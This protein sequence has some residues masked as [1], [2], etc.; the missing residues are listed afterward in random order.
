MHSCRIV[1]LCRYLTAFV[2]SVLLLLS[3]RVLSVE[4]APDEI[5][6][7]AEFLEGK[8]LQQSGQWGSSIEHFRAAADAYSFVAD[9]ALYQMAQS[10]RQGKNTAVAVS[11]L[12][13]LLALYPN[14]P[15]KR[16]AQLDLI[17]LYVSTDE[18]AKAA[19][20]IESA[21]HGAQSTGETVSLM[22][23]LVR[24]Y[25]AA[26]DSVQSDSLCW[27]IIHGWPSTPEALEATKLVRNID[28]PRKS[29]A[30]AK[31]HYLNKQADTTLSILKTLEEDPN[32]VELM[33]EVL[34][35]KAQALTLKGEN[36]ASVNLLNRVISNYPDSSVVATALYERAKYWRSMGVPEKALADY[37]SVVERFPGDNA[38]VQ[39]LWESAKIFE[40]LNDPN[41]YVQYERILT[42]YPRFGLAFSSMIYWGMK[43][44]RAGAYAEAKAVF[45]KLLAANLGSEANA[46]ASFWIAK[47]S[48]AE[49]SIDT[50]KA[51]LGGVIK[52]FKGTYQEF[53][54][55]SILKA[56]TDPKTADAQ[57]REDQWRSLLVF[58]RRPFISYEVP[59]PEAAFESV[60][61]VV[62][63]LEPRTTDRLKFFMFNH[64][65]EAQWE[66]AHASRGISG[67]DARYA[68]AWALFHAGA[69]ND[70]IRLATSLKGR[71]TE[72][73]HVTRLDYLIYPLAYPDLIASHAGQ[74]DVDPMLSLA[75]M[76]EESHFRER[77][78]STSNARGLM[79]IIPP[80]GK[81][82]AEKAYR[83]AVF[84]VD[85]LFQPSIN[86]E[87][88][89]YYL[90]YLL[91]KFDR[92]LLLAIAAYNWG[93]GNL[94]KWMQNSPTNDI[95]VFVESIPAEETRR[96]VKKV[97]RS[98]AIYYSL[99]PRDYLERRSQISESAQTG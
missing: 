21:L 51:Q 2:I 62:P 82:L 89:N 77:A 63:H 60:Q 16:T 45:K 72:S 65:P 26:G 73:Q 29:L 1:H 69:Y 92:N 75:V 47:C 87:L 66:L 71:L 91:D 15:I 13:K 24:S 37:K 64:L 74:Y 30:V 39:S 5:P 78:V 46:E 9:Y 35:Y 20:F 54:A 43:Q 18:L 83:A 99:Y 93:P 53:R 85:L 57:E 90:R 76:R 19:P 79:Q 12:E 49:G 10:A 42:K 95:D 58:A 38:A 33:P 67:T 98:Y 97:L 44:Y 80:T 88:G 27:R 28:V 61:K 7:G 94:G 81:W 6:G 86:I 56:L 84:D 3:L 31:V 70:S 4:A 22:L 11:S 55:R 48:V 59:G 41:E 40:K 36:Q 14:T 25:V 68:L 8:R 96:Y 32:A 52:E 23:M 50:A 17:N 34:V